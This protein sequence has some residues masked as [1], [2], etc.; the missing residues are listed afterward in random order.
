MS[1]EQNADVEDALQWG[2]FITDQQILGS[3]DKHELKEYLERLLNGLN[4]K[5]SH[6]IG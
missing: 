3:T 4:Q 2:R 1:D 6:P 5:H